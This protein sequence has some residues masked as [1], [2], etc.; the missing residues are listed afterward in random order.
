MLQL[1][2]ESAIAEQ[3][4]LDNLD[5]SNEYCQ[6]YYRSKAYFSGMQST[7]FV[8]KIV[9]E[10]KENL[11]RTSIDLDVASFQQII[12][13]LTL[14]IHPLTSNLYTKT[15]QFKEQFYLKSQ[16]GNLENS[17]NSIIKYVCNLILQNKDF[18]NYFVNKE[19]AHNCA[20]MQKCMFA[21]SSKAYWINKYNQEFY[22]CNIFK[23]PE[24]ALKCSRTD[25]V[26]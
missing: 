20:I 7:Y 11:D 1:K 19:D 14:I 25:T 16:S 9:Q 18:L 5:L 15:I 22:I 24:A 21:H 26:R 23:V 17:I 12:H 6:I 10:I 8:N 13:K 3:W 4:I 2:K